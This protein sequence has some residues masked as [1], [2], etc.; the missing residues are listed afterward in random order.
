M[1]AKSTAADGT[2]GAGADTLPVAEVRLPSRTSLGPR[3]KRLIRRRQKELRR[4]STALIIAGVALLMV[5]VYQ[6]SW[7]EYS[8]WQLERQFADRTAQWAARAE[9]GAAGEAGGAG[10]GA[11]EAGGAEAGGTGG[12]GMPSFDAPIVPDTPVDPPG[13]DELTTSLL[14]RVTTYFTEDP[15][16]ELPD[17]MR[18]WMALN[19]PDPAF[20]D[21]FPGA[22][23]SLPTIRSR[24]IVLYGTDLGTLSQGPGFYEIAPLPGEPGNVSIAGHRTLYGAWFRHVDKLEHGD[25]IYLDYMGKQYE[26]AVEKV[27]P[28]RA[29]DWS[30]VAPT[31]ESVLTLTACHP[32][33]SARARIAVRAKLV[34]VVDY[35]SA[36]SGLKGD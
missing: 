34:N 18:E 11:G 13:D 25:P 10:A 35:G 9:A 31:E 21:N 17:Y 20:L 14:D 12:S 26:Y 19:Q 28:I 5:P 1:T 29:N 7:A 16:L 3:M 32:V 2:T 33:G 36:G 22:R 23:I 30:V 8:Q 15:A 4:I 27:W 24:A 6:W